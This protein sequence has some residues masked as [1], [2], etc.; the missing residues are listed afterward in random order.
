MTTQD[1][2]ELI[3]NF[4]QQAI[5]SHLRLL[6]INKRIWWL[7]RRLYGKSTLEYHKNYNHLMMVVLQ[8]ESNGYL[9]NVIGNRC[10]IS[11]GNTIL[12][13]ISSNAKITS[14]H[15]ACVEFIMK[16]G[17]NCQFCENQNL[18]HYFEPN[19]KIQMIYC[20]GCGTKTSNE[21]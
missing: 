19:L 4:D 11:K 16:Y 20:K 8:I 15:D 10:Q 2:N 1:K 12:V 5:S 6:G 21:N 13:D 3:A 9:V 18:F 14:I 7:Y 17:N